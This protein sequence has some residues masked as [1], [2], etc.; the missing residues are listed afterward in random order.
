MK[1]ALSGGAL[2]SDGEAQTSGGAPA[3]RTVAPL[4][5]TPLR[6]DGCRLAHLVENFPHKK[7]WECSHEFFGS[8]EFEQGLFLPSSKFALK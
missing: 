1:G 5:S 8:D 2:E 3:V 7:P 4:T 6:C